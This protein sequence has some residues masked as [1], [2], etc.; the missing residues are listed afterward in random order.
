[1]EE[2]EQ[3]VVEGG[4]VGGEDGDNGDSGSLPDVVPGELPDKR[5]QL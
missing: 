4:L 2:H 3:V 1:M 5:V